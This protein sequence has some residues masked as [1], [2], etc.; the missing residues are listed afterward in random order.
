MP[1]RK[2]GRGAAN[3]K[4]EGSKEEA[5]RRVKYVQN[6]SVKAG[7]NAQI[8]GHQTMEVNN[9]NGKRRKMSNALK[10]LS[11]EDIISDFSVVGR[12]LS[13][14][15]KAIIYVARR[16]LENRAGLILYCDI[17]TPYMCLE[18]LVPT[19]CVI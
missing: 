15:G 10:D 1:K 14:S 19:T 18:L 8:L 4:E 2:V 17:Y 5:L 7:K 3:S 13:H 16:E 6:D 9:R 12:N 11:D